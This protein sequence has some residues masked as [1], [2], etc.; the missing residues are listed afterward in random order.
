MTNDTPKQAELLPC[1]HCGG[2]PPSEIG[3][4]I[5]GILKSEG[6]TPKGKVGMSLIRKLMFSKHLLRAVDD[7]LTD[8]LFRQVLKQELGDYGNS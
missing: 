4:A 7:L 5:E 6:I 8:P 1:P 3:K 2:V